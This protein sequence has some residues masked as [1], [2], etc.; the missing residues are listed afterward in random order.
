MEA[1]SQKLPIIATAV[2]AIPEFLQH[3][4]HAILVDGDPSSIADAIVELSQDVDKRS[5]MAAEAYSRLAQEFTMDKGIEVI[6]RRL[7]ALCK[8]GG[9]SIAQQSNQI[10]ILE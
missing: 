8:G 1:A 9:R 7:R 4:K 5:S 2:S 6:D 10:S 3:D